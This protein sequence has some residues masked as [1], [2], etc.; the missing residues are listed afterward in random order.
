[1]SRIYD[2]LF[3]FLIMEEKKEEKYTHL[4]LKKFH[5]VFKVV[6][7]RCLFSYRQGNTTMY[8]GFLWGDDGFKIQNSVSISYLAFTY[9]KF[10]LSVNEGQIQLRL[11]LTILVATWKKYGFTEFMYS[12]IIRL[13]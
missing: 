1:M 3:F 5:R 4:L 7:L 2:S 9:V 6:I 10:H 13:V 11:I 8:E 12:V